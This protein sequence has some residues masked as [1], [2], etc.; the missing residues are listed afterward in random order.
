MEAYTYNTLKDARSVRYVRL[1]PAAGGR[2]HCEIFRASLTGKVNY[3]ALSYAWGCTKRT[4]SITCNGRKLYVTESLLAALQRLRLTTESRVFWIDAVCINQEDIPE[5]NHQVSLVRDIYKKAQQLFV[6][7][8]PGERYSNHG[9]ALSLMKTFAAAQ[10]HVRGAD[11]YLVRQPTSEEWQAFDKFLQRGWFMR[12]WVIIELAMGLKIS[13]QDTTVFLCG[14][15]QFGLADL[16]DACGWCVDTV[17]SLRLDARDTGTIANVVY[18][19]KRFLVLCD[20][21][22]NRLP[23]EVKNQQWRQWLLVKV[24]A[25]RD[26][27][28]TDPRDRLFALYG[29]LQDAGAEHVPVADYSKS[30][31]ETFH[32]FAQEYVLES[33]S[34]DIF[35]EVEEPE[36]KQLQG[37]PSWVP[38][39]TIVPKRLPLLRMTESLGLWTRT[40]LSCR[41][42]YHAGG[43]TESPIHVL[44]EEF[45]GLLLDGVIIDEIASVSEPLT[46]DLVT[47]KQSQENGPCFLIDLYQTTASPLK[48]Y[49]TG[50][51]A[52]SVFWKTLIAGRQNNDQYLDSFVAFWKSLHYRPS[53]QLSHSPPLHEISQLLENKESTNHSQTPSTPHLYTDILLTTSHFRPF[54]TTLNHHSMGLGSPGIQSGDL[55]VVFAGAKIPFIIR[56]VSAE[57]SQYPSPRS[58]ASSPGTPPAGH[59]YRKPQRSP[60]SPQRWVSLVGTLVGEAYVHGIMRGEAVREAG[61]GWERI[62]LV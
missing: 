41:S 4:K 35:S 2:I 50:E 55:V 49:T 12:M 44:D 24:A 62:G 21:T 13:G 7:L 9:S 31:A 36:L 1:L 5:R 27:M 10:R 20:L 25:T 26:K 51:P 34:T 43:D 57:S 15:H 40:G 28:A 38:D 22:N 6:W 58:S 42:L 59:R 17:S 8:G 19:A 18:G 14:S 46:P 45:G 47:A 37:V 54:F 16:K 23:T 39:W 33:Q 30:V 53:G 56:P 52:I 60:L 29:F 48:S 11:S 3:I 32:R 61:R